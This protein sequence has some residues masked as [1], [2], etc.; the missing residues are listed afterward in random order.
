MFYNFKKCKHMHIG[1]HDLEQTYTMKA[2]EERIP[3]AK[4]TSEKDLGI[5]IDN[6]LKF[7]EHVSAKVK[8]ANR[9]LGLIFR[10]FTYLDK[11]IFLNLYKSL[12][13][14]H[15]EYASSVWSPVYKKD[16][17]AI[18]NVQK[19][20]TKLVRSVAHLAYRDRL[21][22]LCLPSLEYRRE[23]A[24]VIQVS[25]ILH[26]TD[27]VNKSKLFTLSDIPLLAIIHLN[28]LSEGLGYKYVQIVL[29]IELLTFGI[30]CQTQ[31]YRHPP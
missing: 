1:N 25:K 2:G 4:V 11:G 9:N 21:R 28:F 13:R 27:K 6:S 15:L 20:A 22:T 19:R 29:A 3:I 23:R 5:I 24:D 12:V 30:V 8:I 18:Q 7:S 14:T 26:N 10:T 17:I 16:R 31:L